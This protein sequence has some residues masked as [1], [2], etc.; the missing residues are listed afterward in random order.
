MQGGEDKV[1]E[2][3]TIGRE[4]TKEDLF[5]KLGLTPDFSGS[6]S[7]NDGNLTDEEK[8]RRLSTSQK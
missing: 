7:Q 2:I 3:I 4:Q 8:R 1:M 6:Q 5:K